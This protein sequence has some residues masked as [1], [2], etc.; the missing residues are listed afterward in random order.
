M[1]K[2]RKRE[3]FYIVEDSKIWPVKKKKKMVGSRIGWITF[4]D[5]RHL[6]WNKQTLRD[7]EDLETSIFSYPFSH[8]IHPGSPQ[9]REKRKDVKKSVYHFVVIDFLED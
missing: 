2:N 3:V 7:N 9:N 1:L 8:T 6:L 4:N 5:L